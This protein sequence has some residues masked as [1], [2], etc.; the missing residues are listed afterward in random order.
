MENVY[1]LKSHTP[2]EEQELDKL[3]NDYGKDKDEQIL[4]KI[5]SHTFFLVKSAAKEFGGLKEYDDLVMEG[6]I[7]LVTAIETFDRSRGKF[8]NYAK[9]CIRNCIR[10]YLRDEIPYIKRQQAKIFAYIDEKL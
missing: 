9:T 8:Y 1:R 4:E 3:L 7:G 6:V 2:L 10:L 5:I